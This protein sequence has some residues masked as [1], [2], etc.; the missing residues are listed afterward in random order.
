VRVVIGDDEALLREGVAT[1][2]E[3]AGFEIAARVGDADALLAAVE[4]ERPEL[5]VT[6]IRMPPDN[7]D[8]GLRAALTIRTRLPHTALLVLSQHA[9]RRYATELLAQR[10]A[11]VG[12]LLKQRVGE[13]DQFVADVRRI[14]AGGTVL[15]PELVGTLL[16]RARPHDDPLHG[17]TARQRDVL[18]LM[19]EGRSNAAI[20][21]RLVITEKAVVKH[22]SNVYEQLGLPLAADDHRRVLAVV[23][24]LSA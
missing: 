22:V 16:G 10:P 9:Q 5:V 12:Y 6:D 24:Y 19:A 1:V 3:R 8:D 4:A 13:V 11:G 15:D 17:L 14:C 7:A 21:E 18:A 2:L 23:R 20:A